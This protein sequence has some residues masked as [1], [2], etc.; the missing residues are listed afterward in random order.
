MLF[1]NVLYDKPVKVYYL[2]KNLI[3]PKCDKKKKNVI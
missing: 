1:G 3:F 2:H